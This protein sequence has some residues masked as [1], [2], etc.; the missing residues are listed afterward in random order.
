MDNY[1]ARQYLTKRDEELVKKLKDSVGQYPA[2]GTEAL[3]ALPSLPFWADAFELQGLPL[4]ALGAPEGSDEWQALSSR[5]DVRASLR[6]REYQDYTDLGWPKSEGKPVRYVTP[7]EHE[8]ILRRLRDGGLTLPGSEV[9]LV[10]MTLR[11][12]FG[13]NE[14]GPEWIIEGLLRQG[15]SM[16][17]YGPSGV[18]KTWFTQTLVWLAAT[19]NGAT[20][21][22]QETGEPLLKAGE[23]ESLKVLVLDG[24]MIEA[25]LK[26]RGL[27]I[28]E[29]IRQ[30]QNEVD[31]V[32]ENVT[33]YLKTKQDHRAWFPDVVNPEWRARLIDHCQQEGYGLVVFDNLTTLSPSLEDENSA[34]AWSPFNDLV[35]GLKKAGVAVL[36]VHHSNKAKSG[37]RGSTAIEATLETVV[38]LTALPPEHP[39]RTKGAGFTVDVTKD[40]ANGKPVVHDKTLLLREGVWLVYVDVFDNAQRVFE[41]VKSLRYTTQ[42]EIAEALG[43]GSQGTVAKIFD[44]IAAKGLVKERSDLLRMLAEARELRRKFEQGETG[45]EVELLVI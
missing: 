42:K 16:M 18:G 34:T 8:E 30:P 3:E 29:M 1:R 44:A 21:K 28:A 5:A 20:I 36:A 27:Q 45:E 15:G 17:V 22:H 12:L 14:P 40:R 4:G 6:L 13:S 32:A 35:I 41:A 26:A 31:G 2:W 37:Y 23:H 7:Q 33:L 9:P 19:G 39:E 10:S 11:Q 43:L 25:D 38:G 24:E